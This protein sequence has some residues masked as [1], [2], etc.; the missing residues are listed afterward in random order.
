ML[1][2]TFEEAKDLCLGTITLAMRRSHHVVSDRG[3]MRMYAF[4]KTKRENMDRVMVP[5]WITPKVSK[6]GRMLYQA[7]ICLKDL[8]PLRNDDYESTDWNV[9]NIRRFQ[10]RD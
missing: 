1:L 2:Y 10:A 7:D 6:T 3:V 5:I 8:P 4:A 9:I